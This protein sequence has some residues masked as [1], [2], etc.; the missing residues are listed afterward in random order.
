MTAFDYVIVGGGS[1]G[2]VLAARLSERPD[3]RVCLIEAGPRDTSPFI[4]IPLGVMWLSKDARHNWLRKSEPQ[5]ALDGRSV[6]IP[7][8]RVLGGSSAINGMIYIRGHRADY[9]AWAEAGCTGWGYDDVLP[10]FRRSEA[11]AEP[12]LDDTLHG[13]DGPLSV[14]NQRDP[15]PADRAFIAAAERLQ[16]RA[17][18]DF[19][20]PEPEG[21][22]IYQVTQKDGRRHPTGAAFL[23]PAR[24]RP[25]LA[26][27]TGAEVDRVLIENGRATGVRVAGQ[28]GAPA[29]TITARAE[30]ILSAG[31][32]GS[33]DL[34]LRSGIGL[35]STPAN[36]ILISLA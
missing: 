21:V 18:D 26:I 17:T 15:N 19:N 8:G 22:G 5:A 2:A 1:A 16:F 27:M 34:L 25:N 3:L 29:H 32:F 11:N 20:R 36:L 28:G 7:G 6:S 31:A 10:Y 23:A 4:K 30:V 14:A 24:G 13:R 35:Q 9:D 12:T 33:P